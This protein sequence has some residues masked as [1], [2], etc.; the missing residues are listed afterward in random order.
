MTAP[1]NTASPAP[2]L[3]VLLRQIDERYPQRSRA[4]DGIMGDPSHQ[5]RKSE[6]NLG[7]AVD[8]TRDEQHGPP[9]DKL[10]VVL[11]RDPRAW[12]TI[13]ERQI[14]NN[15]IQAAAA[16][17]YSGPNPHNHHMHVSILHDRREDTTPWDLSGLD[18]DG[19]VSPAQVAAAPASDGGE[20]EDDG[21]GTAALVA[22]ALLLA[23]GVWLGL[24]SLRTPAPEALYE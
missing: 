22:S 6:H 8:V 9:L 23:A 15:Q 3:L 11:L 4:S 1:E 7:D 5:A 17:P 16:R 20:G 14:R 24:R 21:G 10:A 12:Y 13:F 2:A 18:D 19:G